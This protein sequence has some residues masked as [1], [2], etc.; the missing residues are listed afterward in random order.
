MDVTRN[1]LQF[2]ASLWDREKSTMTKYYFSK[3]K[4]SKKAKNIY[5]KLVV[6]DS[7]TRDHMLKAYYE[8]C[9]LEFT[10]RFFQQKIEEQSHFEDGI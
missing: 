2:L 4:K 10:V 9:R 8:K 7:Y 6:L 3:M 5:N 1:K